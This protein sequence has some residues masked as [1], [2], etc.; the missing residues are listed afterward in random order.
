M[1]SEA[2]A[3]HFSS[4]RSSSRMAVAKYFTPVMGGRPGGFRTPSAIRMGI[5]WPENPRYQA[6]SS[7]FSRAGSVFRFRNYSC[8]ELIKGGDRSF[9]FDP[10]RRPDIIAP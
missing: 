1:Q 4:R 2:R 7:T 9:G 3:S 6:A 10:T 8:C 5:S